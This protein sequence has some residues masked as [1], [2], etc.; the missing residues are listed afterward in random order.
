M[1]SVGRS[2]DVLLFGNP[3]IGL[4]VDEQEMTRNEQPPDTQTYTGELTKKVVAKKT[5]GERQG[6]SPAEILGSN[7]TGGMDICL[8]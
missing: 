2:I 4:Q 1:S 6:R 3:E 7:P 8:L 5:A